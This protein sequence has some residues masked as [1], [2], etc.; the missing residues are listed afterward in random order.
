[1]LNRLYSI[2]IPGE[3]ISQNIDLNYDNIDLNYDNMEVGYDESY[4][5]IWCE[6]TYICTVSLQN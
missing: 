1:M 2:H 6:C 4:L 5:T 3:I